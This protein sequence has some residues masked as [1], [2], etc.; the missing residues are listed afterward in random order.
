MKIVFAEP[1]SIKPD[2]ARKL[3]SEWI[4]KG[5]ELIVFPDRDERPES[6]V[7]RLRDAEIGVVSNIPLSESVIRQCKRM[8]YLVVAFTGTDH[9]DLEACRARGIKVSNAAG[10]SNESV[11][12]LCLGLAISLYRSIPQA[13]VQ[14]R[15]PAGR[16]GMTG[17]EIKGKT[18]GIIGP[19]RIGSRSAEIFRALGCR[20]LGVNRSGKASAHWENVSLETC[21]RK[22]DIISLHVP[23]NKDSRHL[24]TDKEIAMMKKSAIIINAARGPVIDYTSL[25]RALHDNR[26]AGA[27]VDVYEKEP[28]VDKDHPLLSA[29]NCLLTP[30]IGYATNEAMAKRVDIVFENI[31]AWM[32]GDWIR[33]AR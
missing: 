31:S 13:D 32:R 28:P 16:E 24:I 15:K 7:H 3:A 12:E 10:Y 9:I 30:H 22:S 1:I 26:I 19:G 8:K 6:L 25:S 23:L 20:V 17:F 27:A 11:A 14:A 33:Q 29:P 5:H 2:T 21:L 18:I 4:S